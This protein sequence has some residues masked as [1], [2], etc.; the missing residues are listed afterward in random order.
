MG[1]DLVEVSLQKIQ[2]KI[3]RNKSI[4]LE[5]IKIEL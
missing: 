1:R 2:I 4:K 5:K 3:A